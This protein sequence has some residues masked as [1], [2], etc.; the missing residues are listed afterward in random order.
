MLN[1]V[2]QRQIFAICILILGSIYWYWTASLD[3]STPERRDA[4]AAAG[5]ITGIWFYFL[6]IG[7]FVLAA[8][9]MQDKFDT[10]RSS[11][12]NWIDKILPLTAVYIIYLPFERPEL[13]IILGGK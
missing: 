7:L 2:S 11:L 9:Q 10:F 1:L 6:L 3:F 12:W 4:S 8:L 5:L 13:L